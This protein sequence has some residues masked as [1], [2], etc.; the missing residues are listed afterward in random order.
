[1]LSAVMEIAAVDRPHAGSLGE[2][3]GEHAALRSRATLGP[4][5][6]GGIV[7]RSTGRLHGG[8]GRVVFAH[9]GRRAPPWPAHVGPRVDRARKERRMRDVDDKGRIGG[10]ADAS[11]PAEERDDVTVHLK[12][13][14]VFDRHESKIGTIEDVVV[15][16]GGRVE[17]VVLEIGGY[18]G[19][20]THA[21]GVTADKLDVRRG[22]DGRSVRVYLSM[23]DQELR[24]LPPH[25]G[26]IPPILPI[27]PR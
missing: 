10:D 17:T 7:S 12:G 5:R 4:T 9:D 6:R 22:D 18:L 25:G 15:G 27:A 13:E 3:K 16:E 1:M 14:P 19:L 23:T 24:D 26:A 21:V 20:G 2:A 11:R 8:P